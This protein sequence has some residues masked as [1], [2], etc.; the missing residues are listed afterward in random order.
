MGKG[1]KRKTI[2]R[3]LSIGD[4]VNDTVTSSTP[5]QLEGNNRLQF[6]FIG[7]TN[8]QLQYIHP[9]HSTFMHA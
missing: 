1:S 5:G 3:T 7:F 9:T 6:G 4:G 2:W 8:P